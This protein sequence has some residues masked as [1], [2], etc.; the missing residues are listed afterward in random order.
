ME[1]L[2]LCVELHL[3]LT[4]PP[5]MVFSVTSYLGLNIVIT[6]YARLRCVSTKIKKL[7]GHYIT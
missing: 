3:K 2:K 4:A 5:F 1:C 7:Y 6:S